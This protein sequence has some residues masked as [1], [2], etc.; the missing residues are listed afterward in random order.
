[1]NDF[2]TKIKDLCNSTIAFWLLV[3][4]TVFG[5]CYGASW[6]KNR[7]N[8]SSSPTADVAERQIE[9]ARE[10]QRTI[11]GSLGEAEKGAGNLSERIEQS[12]AGIRSAQNAAIGIEAAIEEQRV[13]IG[14]CQQILREILQGD[15]GQAGNSKDPT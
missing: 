14:E 10:P 6:L 1:M 9:S 11:S 13:L 12:Q 2:L 3:G 4:I 7:Y 5:V 15:E 8:S